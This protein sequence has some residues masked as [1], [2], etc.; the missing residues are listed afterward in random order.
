MTSTHMELSIKQAADFLNVS[1]PFLVQLL[2]NGKIPFHKIGTHRRV[3]SSDLMEYKQEIEQQRLHTLDE[4]A[5]Q[6]Q[7]LDMGY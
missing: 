3:K 2:E 1:R 5:E 7:R 6:A 4:L